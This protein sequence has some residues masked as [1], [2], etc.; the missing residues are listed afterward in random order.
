MTLRCSA[1]AFCVVHG[2]L[3]RYSGL[4]NLKQFCLSISID[5]HSG[6][7]DTSA[8]RV[9]FRKD[10]VLTPSHFFL[11]LCLD[12]WPMPCGLSWFPP[13]QTN[14]LLGEEVTIESQNILSWKGPIRIK[15][16]PWLY[17]ALKM[18]W[19]VF[20]Q[21]TGLPFWVT[22]NIPLIFLLIFRWCWLAS[23]KSSQQL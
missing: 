15:S 19:G 13:P 10:I 14:W 8:S 11:F 21:D 2:V 16:N 12:L 5:L 3:F 9:K 22:F 4:L 23:A 6:R 20:S 17:T 1:G 18:G 7:E